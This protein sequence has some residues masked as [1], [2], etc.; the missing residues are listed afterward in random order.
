MDESSFPEGVELNIRRRA[1][2]DSLLLVCAVV[3][4]CVAF[5]TDAHG[6]TS[7]VF[8]R[9]GATMALFATFLE[10]RTHEIQMMRSRDNFYALWRMVSVLVE[11]LARVDSVAKHCARELS[12]VIKAA[13]IEPAMGDPDK[14]KDM[15]VTERIKALQKLPSVPSSFYKYSSIAS[16]IGKVLVVIGTLIWA[17]GDLAV[18]YVI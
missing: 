5:F 14:I 6:V 17:F 16:V 10:F 15:M 7:N 8:P 1:I 11:G 18:G 9:T 4:A 12:S 2:G 13:G 3:P